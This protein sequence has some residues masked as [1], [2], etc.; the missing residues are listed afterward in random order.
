MAND[1]AEGRARRFGEA[2]GG[3]F[4]VVGLAEPDFDQLMGRE[5]VVEGA[6]DG[7]ADPAFAHEDH[8]ANFMGQTPQMTLL[9]ARESWSGPG[10]G[11]SWRLRGGSRF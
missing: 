8:G 11:P 6:G 5:G 9:S 1:P 7:I 2:L 10:S 3:G 4:L